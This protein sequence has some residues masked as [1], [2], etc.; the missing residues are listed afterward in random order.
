MPFVRL[1]MRKSGQPQAAPARALGC[2]A[3]PLPR[4]QLQLQPE[5]EPEAAHAEAHGREAVQVSRVR[6][7]HGP[8]GQ[9]Q[10]TPEKTRSG[11]RWLGESSY[12]RHRRRGGRTERDGRRRSDSQKRNWN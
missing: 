6:L 11:H 2:Q 3:L 9:L 8:L 12:D 7:H 10:K 4:V 5:H 1:R